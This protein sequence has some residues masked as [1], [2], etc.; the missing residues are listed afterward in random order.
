MKR[1]TLLFFLFVTVLVLGP[2]LV[3]G[4]VLT[5]DM[6]FGPH[7]IP[8]YSD[9]RVLAALPVFQLIEFLSV[10]IPNWLIQK[11]L[12]GSILF[13]SGISLM[14]LLKNKGQQ[15]QLL[16]GLLY[17]LNHFVYTRFLAGHWLFLL[18]YALFPLW[19][20]VLFEFT[21]RIT[22][23]T[24]K[25]SFLN[26]LL[27]TNLIITL[28]FHHV[29]FMMI[30]GLVTL[31]FYRSNVFSRR[32]LKRIGLLAL[33]T[34]CI[35]S[36]WIVPLLFNAIITHLD[37]TNQLAFF[38]LGG[39]STIQTLLL[40]LTGYG[41]WAQF[42][43]FGSQFVWLSDS[44]I[45]IISLLLVILAVAGFVSTFM[46]QKNLNIQH[47]KGVQITHND[48]TTSE[49]RKQLAIISI[50]ALFCLL[51]A[52][53]A[54]TSFGVWLYNTVPGLMMMRDTHKWLALWMLVIALGVA[55]LWLLIKRTV[56]NKTLI[57]LLY[58]LLIFVIA[59]Q[60]QTMFFGFQRQLQSVQY[61]ESWYQISSVLKENPNA[62]VLV[63]PWHQ[64]LSIDFNNNLLTLNPAFRFF[65]NPLIYAETADFNGSY[66]TPPGAA[67]QHIIDI[68]SD[69]TIE[70]DE[71]SDV[72][73][74]LLL[75]EV[76][77]ERYTI[78]L[79][80]RLETKDAIL[81]EMPLDIT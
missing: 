69:D 11:L 63:L 41:F 65:E 74:V 5:L 46:K 43:G 17:M 66:I 10:I 7:F 73:Y 8:A 6:V 28:S 15:A 58:A 80:V 42:T 4:Y 72:H 21:A 31:C 78:N 57:Q 52:L 36:Y 45:M 61:P 18:G 75:K 50:S 51:M 14:S 32:G 13:I 16:G 56:H 54:E 30:I 38:S 29:W 34:I 53:I 3:P 40:A 59:L 27:L 55:Y 12:L 35:Q 49:E 1:T 44:P 68:L 39:T 67:E 64:Y 23:T 25:K 24:S 70:E 48:E 20:S 2:L 77:Y 81:Y 71:L 22:T 47:T 60:G 33:L 62:Q 76:D 19:I 37:A 9:G 79:P 26:L